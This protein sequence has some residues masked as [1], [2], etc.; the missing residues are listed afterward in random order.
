MKRRVKSAPVPVLREPHWRPQPL[1]ASHSPAEL[2]QS[3]R[4]DHC[5]ITRQVLTGL[6]LS[7]LL[8]GAALAQSAVASG[9]T[10]LGTVLSQAC[11]VAGGN[12]PALG[13]FRIPQINIGQLGEKLQWLCQLKSIHGFIDQKI[14]NGDWEGFAGDVAGQYAGK[15]LGYIGENMGGEAL[16]NFTTHLNKSLQGGYGE[17]RK[18]L[19]GSV[20]TAFEGHTGPNEGASGDS[21]GG[22][23]AQAIGSNPTLGAAQSVAR[24]QD[25]LNA[26]RG[27]ENAYKA[28]KVQNEAN[29]ALSA[30]TATALKNATDVIGGIKEGIADKYVRDAATSISGREV[31][32]VQVQITAAAMK[33]EATMSVALMSQLGELAQQQVMTN[34]LLMKQESQAE[35]TILSNEEAFNASIER[36]AQKNMDDAAQYGAQIKDAYDGIAGAMKPATTGIGSVMP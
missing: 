23:V 18:S 25:S 21:V 4:G 33:Q 11:A 32:E 36:I 6:S 29:A 14:L 8:S 16:T 3:A 26:T 9:W 12:L 27:L 13:N 20:A 5:A 30:N 22:L 19:Y 35:Q 10:E 31:G 24:L 1:L 7:A 34:T 15:F 28:I 17:F 2:C